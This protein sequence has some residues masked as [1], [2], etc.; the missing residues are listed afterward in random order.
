MSPDPSIERQARVLT[1]LKNRLEEL[2]QEHLVVLVYPVPEAGWDVGAVI[3][4]RII[5][6]ADID[7]FQLSTSYEVLRER[8]ELILD[9]F[10]ALDSPNILKIGSDLVL[11]NTFIA[12]RCAIG[13]NDQNFYQDDNHLSSLGALLVFQEIIKTVMS[14]KNKKFLWT[15]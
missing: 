10:D 1:G 11:C 12:N 2:S 4:I 9:L 14:Y 8:N 15:H 3:G 6:N 7:D 13:V 5:N